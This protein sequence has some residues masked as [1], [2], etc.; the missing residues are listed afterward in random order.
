M[1]NSRTIAISQYNLYNCILYKA[2][3]FDLMSYYR[4]LYNGCYN[5][6]KWDRQFN[7]FLVCSLEWNF[8]GKMETINKDVDFVLADMGVDGLATYPKRNRTTT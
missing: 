8:I 5:L 3:R 7:Q 6:S 1:H 4:F 2:V